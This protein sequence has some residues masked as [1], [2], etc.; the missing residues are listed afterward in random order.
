MLRC[1]G[2]NS[3]FYFP[4]KTLLSE[5]DEQFY[6]G[7]LRRLDMLERLYDNGLPIDVSPA[8]SLLVD[9]NC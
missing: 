3:D 4:L 9:L 8:V 6:D 1:I 5:L 7:Q 2:A